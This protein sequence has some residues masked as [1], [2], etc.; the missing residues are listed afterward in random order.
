MSQ[1]VTWRS[2]Y[3]KLPLTDVDIFALLDYLRRS[4]ILCLSRS[5]NHKM[6]KMSAQSLQDMEKSCEAALK[7]MD[8]RQYAEALEDDYDSVLCYG[9]SFFRKRCLVRQ[10]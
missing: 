3:G 9:I 1:S 2:K 7:Q 5:V 8:E 4:L 6:R 10:K